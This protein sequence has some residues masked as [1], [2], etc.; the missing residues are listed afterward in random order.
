MS[1]STWEKNASSCMT[2]ARVAL[3]EGEGLRLAVATVEDARHLGREA[4]QAAGCGL[5]DI[6]PKFGANGDGVRHVM[7]PSLSL[8]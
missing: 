4:A 8:G 7:A 1:S 2:R 5:A 3:F 6:G